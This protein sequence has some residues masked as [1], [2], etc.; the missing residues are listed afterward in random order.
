MVMF[1]FNPYYTY[2]RIALLY[3][4]HGK[5]ILRGVKSSTP[6]GKIGMHLS[7]NLNPSFLYKTIG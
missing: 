2:I 5:L 3:I 1:T 6:S 4:T 7:W